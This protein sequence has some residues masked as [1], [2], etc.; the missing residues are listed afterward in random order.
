MSLFDTSN[1]LK[2]APKMV[3]K[4]IDRSSLQSAR[5]SRLGA[6]GLHLRSSV[7]RFRIERFLQ[8][9]IS[10]LGTTRRKC[11]H[12]FLKRWKRQSAN[13]NDESGKVEEVSTICG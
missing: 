6:C 5:G 3:I 10:S 2:F 7:N 8:C 9:D 13:C 11:F 12:R 1:D 4:F